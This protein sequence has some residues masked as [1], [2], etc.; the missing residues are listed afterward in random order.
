MK[1]SKP[2]AHGPLKVQGIVAVGGMGTGGWDG[3]WKRRRELGS[4]M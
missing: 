4:E 1:S 3:E 2:V